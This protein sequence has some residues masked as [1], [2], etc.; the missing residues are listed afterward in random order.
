MECFITDIYIEKLRHLRDVDIELDAQQRKHLLIT[1]KNGAGKTSLLQAISGKMEV[2]PA[3]YKRLWEYEKCFQKLLNK[4]GQFEEKVLKPEYKSLEPEMY[5]TFDNNSLMIERNREKEGV[6]KE[7][8]LSKG[9]KVLLSQSG[10]EED[11][12]K[13]ILSEIQRG[14]FITAFF[15]ADRE[16]KMETPEGAEK[17][18]PEPYYGIGASPEELFLKYMVHLKTQQAYA[19]NEN[20]HETVDAIQK[21]FGHL[22]KALKI[23]LDDDSVQLQYNYREYNFQILEEGREPVGFDQ[24]SDGYSSVIQIVTNLMMRMEHGWD[25][26]TPLFSY[27]TQGIVLIDE[28][29]THLHIEL[30]KKI[31]PFLTEFFPRIQFIVTTHS[32]YILN[33]IS[34]AVIYDLE[35]KIKVEDLSGYS[36]EGIVEGYFENDTYSDYIKTRLNRYKELINKKK[37]SDEERAERARLRTELLEIPAEFAKEIKDTFAEIEEERMQKVHD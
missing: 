25:Q 2:I 7:S 32:P 22:Q 13:K 10:S 12:E 19:R 29:E 8:E 23:L 30:Q 16:M 18:K 21:W 37:I 9:V 17:I 31:L 35:Y 14:N 5:L 15:E 1:G 33:S 6:F 11:L 20:D 4:D 27:N 34:N 28:I 26:K 24:L 36:A 3:A